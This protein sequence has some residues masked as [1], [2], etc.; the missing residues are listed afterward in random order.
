MAV[1]AVAAA[2]RPRRSACSPR[3]SAPT[4]RSASCRTRWRCCAGG[5]RRCAAC[6]GTAEEAEAR[7]SAWSRCERRNANG[8]RASP[9]AGGWMGS[10]RT[11][12]C[13]AE[14]TSR[15]TQN[16]SQARYRRPT[17]SRSA[18]SRGRRRGRGERAVL[19]LVGVAPETPTA[20]TTTPSARQSTP[21]GTA[22]WRRA[23]GVTI[24]IARIARRSGTYLSFTARDDECVETQSTAF[25]CASSAQRRQPSMHLRPSRPVASHVHR[26]VLSARARFVYGGVRHRVGG[27]QRQRRLPGREDGER[28]RPT[29]RRQSEQQ[30]RHRRTRRDRES[31]SI[32]RRSTLSTRCDAC[33]ITLLCWRRSALARLQA[34]GARPR[35]R[36]GAGG[37]EGGV[38]RG[39]HQISSTDE[40]NSLESAAIARRRRLWIR[41]AAQKIIAPV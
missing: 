37:A 8:R 18:R 9:R 40:F 36:G 30:R 7:R 13:V 16:R 38:S 27:L 39:G 31:S 3:W 20:P 21:P 35:L 25:A 33:R 15:Y 17:R 34:A 29:A 24:A 28:K 11:R 14:R 22:A 2:A 4:T 5:A 6:R 12:V 23:V 1:A 26:N 32:G 41:G 19:I 10:Y